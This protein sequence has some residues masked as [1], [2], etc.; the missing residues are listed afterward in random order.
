M[1]SPPFPRYLFPPRSKYSP[2]HHVLK[3]LQLPFL[4]L[5]QRPSFTPIQNNRQNLYTNATPLNSKRGACSASVP[6]RS[7]GAWFES[8]VGHQPQRLRF[9]RV[10]SVPTH[11][12]KENTSIRLQ[13]ITSKRLPIQHSSITLQFFVTHSSTLIG[14]LNTPNITWKKKHLLWKLKI[15]CRDQKGPT[16]VPIGDQMN[17]V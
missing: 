13:L 9:P 15:C 4:P 8:L 16:I 6:T 2:Q 10:Q 14:S 17:S 3:H 7:W 1:Q 12:Y 5:Y 11:I